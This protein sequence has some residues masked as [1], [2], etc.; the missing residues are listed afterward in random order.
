MFKGPPRIVPLDVMRIAH[1]FIYPSTRVQRCGLGR[2]TKCSPELGPSPG[3]GHDGDMRLSDRPRVGLAASRD[4]GRW[5][6]GK[7]GTLSSA[8]Q[9]KLNQLLSHS[10]WNIHWLLLTLIRVKLFW[11]NIKWKLLFLTFLYIEMLQIVEIP[12]CRYHAT[13]NI[14]SHGI[15]SHSIDLWNIPMSA[16]EC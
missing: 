15:S 13:G 1:Y 7:L 2:S 11:G 9:V 14:R 4:K 6:C 16:P 3:A 10:A 12:Q 5:E 8:C